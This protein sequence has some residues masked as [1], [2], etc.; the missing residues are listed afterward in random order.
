MKI[1]L[2]L[3]I[4]ASVLLSCGSQ[5]VTSSGSNP[6]VNEDFVSAIQPIQNVDNAQVVY[7]IDAQNP[8][9]IQL[10]R[11]GTLVFDEDA[12]VDSDGNPV[13]GE[14]EIQWEEFHSLGDIMLSG[15]PMKYDSAGVAHNLESGG[16]FTFSGSQNGNDVHIAKGKKAEVNLASIQDTPCYNFY[17]MDEESGDWKYETT[18]TGDP[19]EEVEDPKDQS[20]AKEKRKTD[21]NLIDV[22]LDT[23]KFQHL[24]GMEIVAW[25]SENN[26]TR[27]DRNMLKS[28]TTKVR[29]IGTANTG[30]ILEAKAHDEEI[31]KYPVKPYLMDEA[32]ADTKANRVKL[33]KEIE[34]VA[35]YMTEVAAGRVIRS[36]SVPNFGTYNWDCIHQFDEPQRVFASFDYQ[37][38]VNPELVS[39][40]LLAPDRNII[41]KCNSQGDN[42]FFFDPSERNCLIGILPNN[43]VVSV[44]NSGFDG[45]RGN[46]SGQA[47][48]F[49]FEQTGIKLHS[50]EDIMNH[51]NDL[52]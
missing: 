15:I 29:L 22:T 13:T 23:R 6:E 14:V 18:A 16:M 8:E 35:E 44:S 48:T 38:N 33:D 19:I 39:L 11:G 40:F 36:I 26:L 47:F 25:R 3:F 34:E 37:S 9:E 32:I 17:E 43:R 4:P 45:V 27:F 31:Y 21:P 51:L 49:K 41:I 52:I 30:L 1:F 12:F 46:E 2:L 24:Q 7:R 42:G 10:K 5:E 50:S 20:V 28:S